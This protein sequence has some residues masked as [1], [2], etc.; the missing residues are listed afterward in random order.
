MII[1]RLFS[2]TKEEK[3]KGDR[4]N[5]T[6]LEAREYMRAKRNVIRNTKTGRS[7]GGGI[8]FGTVGAGAGYLAGGNKKGALIG[9]GIGSLV[10]GAI[11]NEGYKRDKQYVQE[12]EGR[13]LNNRRR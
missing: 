9:A 5:P 7:I 1:T 8:L 2:S 10:G 4:E 6:V 13:F 3:G 12:F 11:G